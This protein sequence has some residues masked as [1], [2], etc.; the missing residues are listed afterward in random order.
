MPI[1]WRIYKGAPPARAPP[2]LLKIRV[3]I[4][5]AEIAAATP[6]PHERKK[7]SN[8]APPLWFFPDPPLHWVTNIKIVSRLKWIWQDSSFLLHLFVKKIALGTSTDIRK[9]IF[10]ESGKGPSQKFNIASKRKFMTISDG[11]P[12]LKGNRYGL[13]KHMNNR[14][15]GHLLTYFE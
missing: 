12:P 7:I 11:P 15:N 5:R 3:Q 2:P 13:L 10:K 4:L 6:P 1:Q 14:L 9:Y 8:S